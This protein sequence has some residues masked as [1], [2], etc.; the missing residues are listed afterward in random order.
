MPCKPFLDLETGRTYR[1]LRSA[2]RPNT[3]ASKSSAKYYNYRGVSPSWIGQPYL[4]ITANATDPHYRN[5]WRRSD[6]TYLPQSNPLLAHPDEVRV[7]AWTKRDMWDD[8]A[9]NIWPLDV[10]HHVG[11]KIR[12][13]WNQKWTMKDMGRKM[14]QKAWMMRFAVDGAVLED[15]W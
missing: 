15:I 13:K 14:R 2:R 8:R 1:D 7:C 4:K 5:S 9:Q 6:W 3:R 10:R 12:D 11:K